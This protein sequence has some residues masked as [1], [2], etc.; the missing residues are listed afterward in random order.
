MFVRRVFVTI[1]ALFPP[2]VLL[3]TLSRA[4]PNMCTSGSLRLVIV[5]D[6]HRS[7]R[8]PIPSGDIWIHAGDSELT[9][10]EMDSWAMSLPHAHKLVVCGNMDRRLEGE[11]QKL[12]NVT[13]LQDSDVNISGIKLYGSPWTPEFTGIFQLED[14]QAAKVVWEKVPPDVDVL[15]THGPPRGIL[16]RTSRGLRVGDSALLSVVERINPRVHCFG[17]IHESYGTMQ[18]EN[19]TFCN[20][21][22]FNGHPPLVVD[23]PRDKNQPAS[24]F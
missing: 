5:S 13:Y 2:V 21:A 1:A 12:R 16:D 3:L 18:N 17:H 19:T 9:A 6:T 23:I 10:S 22:V 15:I 20:A 24:L 11:K 7:Y 8:H 4:N 14:P